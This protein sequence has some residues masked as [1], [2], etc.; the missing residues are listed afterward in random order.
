VPEPNEDAPLPELNDQVLATSELAAL[1]RDYR[2]CPLEEVEIVLKRGSG[3]VAPHVPPTLL[4][5]E[6]MLLDRE[7][8]GVQIRYRYQGNQWC[9]TLLPV[10]AGVRLVR[11]QQPGESAG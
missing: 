9:D 10:Q 1:F 5:A 11:I 7:V 4:E 3:H 8:R 2:E 6:Q